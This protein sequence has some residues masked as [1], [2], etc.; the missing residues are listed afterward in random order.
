MVRNLSLWFPKRTSF[1][2]S[3]DVISLTLQFFVQLFNFMLL[4]LDK[5]GVARFE[6]FLYRSF[7]L[8]EL[9]IEFLFLL[10]EVVDLFLQDLNVEFKLL[11]SSDVVADVRLILLQLLFVFFRRQVQTLECGCEL[12]SRSIILA[13]SEATEVLFS[14]SLRRLVFFALHLHED[15]YLLSDVV[16]NRQAVVFAKAVLLDRQLLGFIQIDLTRKDIMR[17]RSNIQID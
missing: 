15:L 6:L 11:L 17:W 2:A 10:F 16:Q 1:Y 14:V 3:I 4:L 13:Y 12:G 9:G 7:L 8:S 5:S